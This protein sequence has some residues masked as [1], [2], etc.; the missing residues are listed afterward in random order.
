MDFILDSA[1]KHTL[2]IR[3]TLSNSNQDQT[4]ALAQF[5]GQQPASEIL[6]N[7]KG[8]SATYTAILTPSLINNLT[9]GYTRQGLAYSGT[10][11]DAFLLGPLDPLQNYQRAR[12]QPHSACRE[13]R[14]HA[15]VDQGQAH[16]Y[17][18]HEFPRHDKQQVHLLQSYPSYGFNDNVAVGLGEDIQ[19]DL[20]NYMV[21]QTGNPNFAAQ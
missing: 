16:H 2:S 20:T 13:H 6:N 21:K 8:I 5:P 12:Q 9:F 15:Y 7:S 4:N 10:S 18:R 11:G 1:A 17:H 19:T 14:G 3:G